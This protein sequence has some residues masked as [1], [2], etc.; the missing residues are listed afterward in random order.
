MSEFLDE[1][2]RTLAQPM[3]RRRALRL[4]GGTLVA[5]VIPVA[6]A[7]RALARPGV[8]RNSN[9]NEHC[10]QGV[11]LLCNCDR[12]AQFPNNP[13]KP[14]YHICCAADDTCCCNPKTGGG[15]KCCPPGTH[16]VSETLTCVCDNDCG[17]G[18]CQPNEEC[19]PSIL[20][21]GKPTCVAKCKKGETRCNEKCCK[22]NEECTK[23]RAGNS[24]QSLCLPKCKPGEVRCGQNCCPNGL[25]CIDP[26]NGICGHCRPNEFK[27]G[28]RCCNLRGACCDPSKG[29]C[30]KPSEKCGSWPPNKHIC[31]KNH[32]C[33]SRSGATPFCCQ[34]PSE[35]CLQQLPAGT[36]GI[37]PSSERVC[38]PTARQVSDGKGSAIACCAPGQVAAPGGKF[39]VGQGLQGLCCPESSL[40]GSGDN[41]T[42]C[43]TGRTC[44]GDGIC[45]DILVDHNNCG[46]CGH[47]C[48]P[49]TICRGGQ[50]ALP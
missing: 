1:L 48:A 2:A 43:P 9:C 23:F 3:P 5:A 38:C 50:C 36:G 32:S 18:C 49:N 15:V 25:K 17:G 21:T 26:G 44:C 14:C 33:Q 19:V 34:S 13:A 47:V 30:C 24:S 45:A 42:C 4:I 7:P 28:K 31:C 41:A 39:I 10:T 37:T 11:P 20:K 6:R 40:C 22:P 29:L 8:S 35:L 16:C 12:S 46:S 27:C